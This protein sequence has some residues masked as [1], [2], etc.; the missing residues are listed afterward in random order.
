MSKVLELDPTKPAK[1]LIERSVR[2][3]GSGGLVV[4][5]TETFYGIAADSQNPE[6]L[7]KLAKL[8]DREA[9]KPFPL[10]ISSVDQLD[11][12]VGDLSTFVQKITDFFSSAHLPA[13]F[14][15]PPYLLKTRSIMV[16]ARFFTVSLPP[17]TEIAFSAVN[18][19][20]MS[21]NSAPA[22]VEI[23]D[24]ARIAGEKTRVLSAILTPH[25]LSS[26]R[27]KKS[28]HICL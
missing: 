6:G 9:A 27:P 28:D 19:S 16:S 25:R 22:R 24:S 10:I 8:K 15:M 11:S 23:M 12:L 14:S 20:S 1:D 3:L 21:A 2:I 7:A 18:S 4:F 17:D 26:P 5:P 13:Y